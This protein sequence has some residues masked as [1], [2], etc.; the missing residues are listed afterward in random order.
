[1][2]ALVVGLDG[3]AFNVLEPWIAGGQLPTLAR[4]IHRGS[5]GVLRSTIPPLTCP[6]VICLCTGKNPGKLGV[7]LHGFVDSDG[8]LFSMNDIHACTLWDILGSHGYRSCVAN[9][10][11]TYPPQPMGGVLI[12]GAPPSPDSQ[13][14]YPSHL[15]GQTTGFHITNEAFAE[16]KAQIF[17]RQR[18]GLDQLKDLLWKRYRAFKSIVDHD[19][20]DFGLLWIASTDIIQHWSWRNQQFI[21]E[22][23]Q[24][25]DGVLADVL[26]S[27]PQTNILVVSDHGF[28]G[29]Y[30][31]E[32]NVNVWLREQGFLRL[33]G[34]PSLNHFFKSL[35]SVK[36][37]LPKNLLRALRRLRGRAQRIGRN[38]TTSTPSL[39]VLPGADW[40]NGGAYL[41]SHWGIRVVPGSMS[42]TEVDQFTQDIIERLEELRDGAGGKV[43]KGIWRREE[44]YSGPYVGELPDIV[45][46]LNQYEPRDF[47]VGQALPE[48]PLT[49]K[50]G[51]HDFAPEGILIAYGP[52]VQA[53]NKLEEMSIFDVTPTV[54]H[55][56]GVAVPTAMD[57]RV[58]GQIFAESSEPGMRSVTYIDHDYAR[59]DLPATHSSAEEER[60]I[61]ARL[62]GLGY[63]E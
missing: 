11:A 55:I 27:F 59:D 54:L 12:S 24:E 39:P 10:R 52:D 44:F 30:Y 25:V 16:L 1:M 42:P 29:P 2:K 14:V 7:G 50:F 8:T 3:A 62:K 51:R 33:R 58:L 37:R 43:V 61:I 23:F 36:E 56:M 32:F 19:N 17:D 5:S 9:L 53:G 21:L 47:L 6:A 60:L 41:L 49:P 13:Y 46:L 45:F 15:Q 4:M 28:E 18:S 34:S 40:R 22:I 20:F 63:L 38:E 48:M 57:G 26:A 35:L 31:R